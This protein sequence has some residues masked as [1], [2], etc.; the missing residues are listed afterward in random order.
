M[1]IDL[2][3]AWV[4]LPSGREVSI[5]DVPGH[6]RF[7]KNM[8]AGVGG[9]DL[10]LLIVAA[11][12]SVMPQTREHLAILDLLG[13]ER[14]L[15][16]LTKKDLVDADTLELVELEVEDVLAGT[17]LEGSAVFGVAATTGDGV[18]ELLAAID[19]ALDESIRRRDLGRPRL[20][21]D[22]SFSITGFGT[23]V[24][25]TLIDG[26]L[27]VGQEVQIVPSGR[28]T[29]IRGLQSHQQK[30]DAAEPGNRVAVNLTGI[31]SDEIERGEVVTTPGWLRPTRAVDV[32]LHLLR[33][34]P[35]PIWHNYPAT[36]HAYAS[37]T[38]VTVRLLDADELKPG[39]VGWA[40]LYLREPV[41]L[42]RGDRFVIRSP[43]TT[44]GG[45]VVVDV[46]A[47]R[48]KRNDPAML[49]R[50]QRISEGSPTAQLLTALEAK[51]P[52]DVTGLARRANLPDADALELARQAVDEGSAV[53][54]GNGVEAGTQLYTL[55]GWTRL[56]GKAQQA[57]AAYHEANPLRTGMTREELRSR[58]T[59]TGNLATLVVNH[60]RTSGV[61]ADDA[62]VLH[63]P[64]HAVAVSG[65]QQAAMDAY[66]A[67]LESDPFPGETPRI[68]ANLLALLSERGHVVR[69]TDGVVFDAATWKR[70]SGLVIARLRATGTVTVAETRD[71]LG[72]SRKYALAVLEHLDDAKITRRQGDERV[73][74]A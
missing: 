41:G 18:P 53:A 13:V 56:S 11:D 36:F 46:D 1:T 20:A 44:L 66:V 37:E 25:G 16:V 29:R 42:A 21:V 28:K 54:L 63:L 68:A 67:Q 40:Q 58:L 35:H 12:E 8:L 33:D 69:A 38:P 39:E 5:V 55:A 19:D 64:E 22:R 34:A 43:D 47:G 24:T 73:L 62:G 7:I 72:T 27:Q 49:E 50:L 2:G 59:V 17:T 60:L 23:V 10:A 48:H 32:R 26:S 51:E 6:E 4:T 9:V 45:G 65:E 61:I 52:S 3:F 71:L 15:V 70:L 31:A 14:A 30:I 74:L 57:L